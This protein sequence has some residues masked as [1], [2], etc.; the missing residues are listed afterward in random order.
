MDHCEWYANLIEWIL[1]NYIVML[2]LHN[3]LL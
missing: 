1:L 2:Y 3:M